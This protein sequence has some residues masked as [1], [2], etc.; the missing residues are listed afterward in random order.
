[1]LALVADDVKLDGALA[2][3]V[4]KA[5][6][7]LAYDVPKRKLPE[8]VGEQFQR[9]HAHAAPDA[10]RALVELVGDNLDELATEIEKLVT[11]AGGD[12]IDAAAVE[13]L[14]AGRA[15]TAIFTLSDAWGRGD[16][17]AVLSAAE[18]RLERSDRPR[19]SELARLAGMLVNHVD[20]VRACQALAAQGVR[21]RDAAA[22]LKLHPFV[23]EKAYAQARTYSRDELASIT[24]RLA[25]LDHALKGGS[26]L[27]PDLELELT[28]IDVTRSAAA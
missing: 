8:W 14:A 19:S 20:R 26:R 22:R 25:R 2:K 28:L 24:V 5:G 1:V 3:A 21:A 6:E 16:V 11:W 7:V 13:L 27:P 15:E 18:S 4:K 12:A 9:L 17:A 23:V 10:C